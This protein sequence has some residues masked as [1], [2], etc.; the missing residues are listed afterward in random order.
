[1]LLT[2]LQRVLCSERVS[3]ELAKRERWI[4]EQLATTI[5]TSLI[6]PGLEAANTD[7]Q[8][9]LNPCRHYWLAD[10]SRFGIGSCSAWITSRGRPRSVPGA[11]TRTDNPDPFLCG[12]TPAA[13]R[14]TWSGIRRWTLVGGNKDGGTATNPY[15]AAA[16][17]FNGWEGGNGYTDCEHLSA[18]LPPAKSVVK[19]ESY[20]VHA[21]YSINGGWNIP[22]CRRRTYC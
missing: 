19:R 8:R 22:Q 2:D 16:V 7:L 11:S 5:T 1:M 10:T 21:Q 18:L 20:A 12:Y 15:H 4:L 3:A 14:R 9:R 17:F 6:S 13:A